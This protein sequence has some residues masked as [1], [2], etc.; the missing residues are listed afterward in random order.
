M[1]LTAKQVEK[2]IQDNKDL[3]VNISLIRGQ[4]NGRETYSVI[5]NWKGLPYTDI[6]TCY[7]SKNEVRA[8]ETLKKWMKCIK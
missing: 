5:L 8:Q 3:F 4:R 2:L 7:G 1:L 6:V